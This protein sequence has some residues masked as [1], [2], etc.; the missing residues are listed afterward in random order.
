LPALRPRRRFDAE[1]VEELKPDGEIGECGQTGKQGGNDEMPPFL[2]RMKAGRLS[3]RK[4]NMKA[5]PTPTISIPSP[6]GSA[7]LNR[8]TVRNTRKRLCAPTASNTL[9]RSRLS[10][11][12]GA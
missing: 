3:G 2:C 12:P 10:P 1:L 5:A 8:N 6:F 11:G 7:W 4:M 9:A